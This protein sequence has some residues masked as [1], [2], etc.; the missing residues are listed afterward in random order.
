MRGTRFSRAVVFANSA[1][2]FLTSIEAGQS[3]LP[4]NMLLVISNKGEQRVT[5]Q[6]LAIQCGP[7]CGR[8]ARGNPPNVAIKDV[9]AQ[10]RLEASLN[11]RAGGILIQGWIPMCISASVAMT[12]PPDPI[13]SFAKYKDF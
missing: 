3:S 13:I 5:H 4:A 7:P 6:I 8:R 11:A 2:C 12:F 9:N 1:L 10:R